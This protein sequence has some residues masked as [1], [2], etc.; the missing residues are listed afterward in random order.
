MSDCCDSKKRTEC[1]GG[2]AKKNVLLYARSGGAN[3]A[4]VADR[5]AR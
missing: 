3:V 2:T 1:C 5:A 4:E